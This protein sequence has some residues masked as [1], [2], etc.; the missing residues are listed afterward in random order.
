[1]IYPELSGEKAEYDWVDETVS[2]CHPVTR[3]IYS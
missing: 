2:A 1:M 3:V